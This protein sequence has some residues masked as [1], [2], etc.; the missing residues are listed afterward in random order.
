MGEELLYDSIGGGG[1]GG[2]EAWK[3]DD[4]FIYI[5]LSIFQRSEDLSFLFLILYSIH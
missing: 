5:N 1:G 3:R 2:R 4:Y